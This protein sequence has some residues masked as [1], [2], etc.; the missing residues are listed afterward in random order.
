MGRGSSVNNTLLGLSDSKLIALGLIVVFVIMRGVF[1]SVV[2]SICS[3]SSLAAC[4]GGDAKFDID[5]S[6]NVCSV[7]CAQ[8]VCFLFF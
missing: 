5:V 3:F 4:F 7:C 8:D 6:F 2:G 1:A